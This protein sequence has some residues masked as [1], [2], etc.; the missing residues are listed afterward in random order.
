MEG[1][2]AG[3]GDLQEPVLAGDL[4][5][6]VV[7]GRGAGELHGDGLA[8]G[9][10]I[11][12]IDASNGAMQVVPR[13]HK[14][15]IFDQGQEQEAAE[16]EKAATEKAVRDIETYDFLTTDDNMLQKGDGDEPQGKR[17][18]VDVD[19][20]GAEEESLGESDHDFWLPLS[21]WPAEHGLHNVLNSSVTDPAPHEVQLLCPPVE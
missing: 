21:N 8:V 6:G 7:L 15:E 14:G 11:D 10:A 19:V 3:A 9:V 5:E 12:D 20:E 17:A 1:E 2:A 18:R 13:S 4:D 16:A